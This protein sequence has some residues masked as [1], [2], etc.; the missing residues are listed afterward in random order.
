MKTKETIIDLVKETARNSKNTFIRIFPTKLFPKYEKF[1][2]HS[3][4]WTVYRQLYGF[5]FQNKNL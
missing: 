2:E 3:P 5:I 1:L 4:N